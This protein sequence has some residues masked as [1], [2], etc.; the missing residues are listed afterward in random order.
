MLR[1]QSELERTQR[2]IATGKRLNDLA[3]NPAKAA[4]ASDLDRLLA[5]NER[6]GANAGAVM[7]RLK[8]GEQALTAGVDLMQRLREL[9][10]Q[11]ANDSLDSKVRTIIAREVRDLGEQMLGLAN[12]KTESGEY[13]FAGT[14]TTSIPFVRTG[15]GGAVSYV[16]ETREREV[17]IS[18]SRTIA[19][20]FAGNEVFRDIT[21][22]NGSFVTRVGAGNSGTGLIDAGETID[23]GLWQTAATDG[24][25][26]VTFAVS[27]GATTYGVSRVDGSAVVPTGTPYQSGQPIHFL[28]IQVVVQG[29]P[30]NGDHFAAVPATGANA[31]EDLFKTI[32]RLATALET[33]PLDPTIRAKVSSEFGG[34]I[35]Q[36]DQAIESLSDARSTVGT[37]L[38]ALE[39]SETLRQDEDL[40][41]KETLSK[42]RD[43]DFAEALA[44]LNAQMTAL[45]VAQQAYSRIS[46]RTLFDYL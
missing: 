1:Q 35:Q 12:R 16:G 14:R 5:A 4:Q 34:V 19:D 20:G 2:E 3:E 44:R 6:Y 41:I 21:A 22:G 17:A 27:G 26:T 15:A 38:R 11:G 42:L 33:D 31:T 36:I 30:A 46:T 7:N 28:G 32:D 10:I 24:P 23:R 13:L 18:G 29:A 8:V 39:E 43:V 45:Q 37:R 40:L 9:A 25:F